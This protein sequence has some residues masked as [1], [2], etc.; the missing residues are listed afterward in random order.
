MK[1]VLGIS[2]LC[3]LACLC[4][5]C[6]AAEEVQ[7]TAVDAI[8]VKAAFPA[9]WTVVTPDTVAQHFQY[10]E[11]ETPEIAADQL[12]ALGVYAMAF[13]PE[14]DAMLRVI[15]QEGGEEMALYYDVERYTSAMRTAI[16]ND[17]LNK[18]AW[19]LTGYRYSEANWTNKEGQGRMLN[20]VYTI[21]AGEE[22]IARGKQ[23]Y[24]IRNGLALTLDLQ[25]KGKRQISSAEDK[26]Y[27]AFLAGTELPE[28]VDMPLLPVGL[29]MTGLIPEETNKAAITLRGETMKGATVSAWL[30]PDGAEPF[31]IGEVKAPASGVFKLDVEL[32]SEG[33]WRL[34]IQSELEGYATCDDARWIV[35]DSRRLPVTFTSYPEGDYDETQVIVS[36]KTVSGVTVQC[37]EGM[38]NKKTTT[39]SDGTFSF[40]MDRTVTGPRTIILSLEKKNYDNRRFEIIFNRQLTQVDYAKLLD[41]EVRSLSFENLSTN[42]E[43]YIGRL[44]KYTGTV[45]DVS[46]VGE[47]TYIQL[48]LKQDKGS[49][50]T[51]RIIAVCDGMEV[52]LAEGNRATLYFEVTGE[53]YAFSELTLDGDE[54]TLEL[55]SVR[56]LTYLKNE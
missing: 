13:S 19:A 27:R 17:F 54:L 2:L 31:S 24:T 48:G 33:E 50:W 7:T 29:T 20:L 34:Y 43:K 41:E 55:P 14:G 3:I 56:L 23:A 39:G 35:Y 8:G 22:T 32:P 52:L 15:A 26:A 11:E 47:R 4:A 40:K 37:M 46:G 30:V 6:A 36:G 28:S 49:R 45:L 42:T 44:V 1:K 21:R 25:V 16:K 10:F 9:D 53:T 38:V 18:A 51:E 5:L 12:R